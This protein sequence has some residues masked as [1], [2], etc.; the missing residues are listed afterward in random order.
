MYSTLSVALDHT[1]FICT[2]IDDST[3]W[4]KTLGVSYFH[5]AMR[6]IGMYLFLCEYTY[7]N[8]RDNTKIILIIIGWREIK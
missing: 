5:T 7:D 2:R 4:N 1:K 6:S 8:N 3:K